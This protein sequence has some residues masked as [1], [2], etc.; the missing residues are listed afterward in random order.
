MAPGPGEEADCRE[1]AGAAGG[2]F[3]RRLP[4][5]GAAGQARLKKKMGVSVVHVR[6][7]AVAWL[8]CS[9][10]IE[11]C[12]SV[13]DLNIMDFVTHLN[14]FEG[15]FIYIYYITITFLFLKLCSSY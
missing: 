10:S 7:C 6:R 1:D 15:L 13:L 8:V 9:C 11:N 14:T 2:D 5:E 12:D 3:A 4:A